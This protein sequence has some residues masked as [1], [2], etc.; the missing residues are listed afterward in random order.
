M[1][2]SDWKCRKQY[3]SVM[4]PHIGILPIPV[5][6]GSRNCHVSMRLHLT[7]NTS[8]TSHLKA[9]SS[10]FRKHVI[11]GCDTC[12]VTWALELTR[13][14]LMS[15]QERSHGHLRLAL[16]DRLHCALNGGYPGANYGLSAHT[17]TLM[18]VCTRTRT[19]PPRE[20]GM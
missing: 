2:S 6:P 8:E 10:T 18:Y 20:P 12:T 15:S 17:W 7:R 16:A 19:C 13:M 1:K 11:L 3:V 9:I 4:F 14:L 5:Y